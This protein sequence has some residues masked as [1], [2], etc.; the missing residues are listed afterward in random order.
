MFLCIELGGTDALTRN[1]ASYLRRVH[2]VENTSYGSH[3]TLQLTLVLE[4]TS[5]TRCDDSFLRVACSVWESPSQ[6]CIRGMTCSFGTYRSRACFDIQGE[7]LP[8]FTRE[9][10]ARTDGPPSRTAGRRGA[11]R[12]SRRRRHPK[13]GR[14][15]TGRRVPRLMRSERG[16]VAYSCQVLIMSLAERWPG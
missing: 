9:G 7:F 13:P 3:A 16:D 11:A 6:T 4:N 5:A 1:F 8:S 14:S 2:V 10:S 15:G 12:A